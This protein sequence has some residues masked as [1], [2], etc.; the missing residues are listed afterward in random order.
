MG[1]QVICF[2]TRQIEEVGKEIEDVPVMGVYED[3]D[4]IACENRID[5]FFVALP[6]HEYRYFENDS[7]RTM[8][9]VFLRKTSLDDL[10]QF[11]N[12]HRER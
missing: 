7:R 5:I 6:I 9:G 11:F 4:R 12:V 10:P 1:I 8:I 3:L 2:L